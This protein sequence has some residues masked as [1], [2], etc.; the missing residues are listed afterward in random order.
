MKMLV[1]ID[2]DDL[3]K[4]VDFYRDALDLEVERRLFNGSMVEMAGAS[5]KIHLLAKAS[6][7]LAS[8]QAEIIRRYQ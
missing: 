6:A 8:S 7:S 4:A 5:S 1:N 2:V 3:E